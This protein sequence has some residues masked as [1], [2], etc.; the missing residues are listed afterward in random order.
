MTKRFFAALYRSSKG[1]PIV[2]SDPTLNHYFAQSGTNRYDM[3]VRSGIKTTSVLVGPVAPH[4]KT[5]RGVIIVP[6][7][8]L[9]KIDYPVCLQSPSKTSR[10]THRAILAISAR[11]LANDELCE[12]NS[13]DVLVIPGGAAGAETISK[14][15]TVQTLVRK[16]ISDGKPVGMI[17]A[18]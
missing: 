8:V 14:D 16:Y 4:V 15:P 18:G 11:C 1:S 9:A 17:C 2:S 10:S 3:F 12:K 7:T 5:S 6:D 13:Y